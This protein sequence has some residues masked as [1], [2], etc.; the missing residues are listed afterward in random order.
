MRATLPRENEV[1]FRP[2][3]AAWKNVWVHGVLLL[4]ALLSLYPFVLML[5]N[6]FKS[7]EE[8]LLNPGGWPEQFTLASYRELFDYQG[9]QVLRSFA[10]SVFIATTSTV[11]AVVL[12]GLAGFAFA[13]MRFR[14]R[15]LIF[16]ALLGT[17]MVPTEVTLPPLY[18]LFARIDWLNSYQ[19][20][21]VPS[22]ASVFGLFMVRQYMLSLPDELLEASRLDGANRWQQFWQIVVPISAPVL[23]AFAILHFIG[24]WNDYLWPL[25]VVTDPDVQPIMTLLPT[26]KDPIVGFFTPWGM[27]MAGCVLVTLPLVAVFLLFQDKFM[28]GVVAGATKG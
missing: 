14:G 1:H 12:A 18:I 5:Q 2:R 23:G 15:D 25:I 13:K 28:S 16:A 19:V 24:R 26:I 21:I 17:L 9:N 4:T 10:N 8:V 20:Q 11:L 22:V 7:N 3:R 27:V 6:S